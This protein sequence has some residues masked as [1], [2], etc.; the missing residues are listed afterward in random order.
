MC[1]LIIEDEKKTIAYLADGLSANGY[2]VEKA[3]NGEDGLFLAVQS[4]YD[5]IILDVMLP[6]LNG[7]EVLSRLR[8]SGCDTKVIF[9]TSRDDIDDRV[10]G[11]EL[12]ADDYLIK[13]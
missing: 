4:A 1:I 5:L 13:P 6:K 10:K 3:L 8:Q 11:L 9:L 7:W 2:I 12:G